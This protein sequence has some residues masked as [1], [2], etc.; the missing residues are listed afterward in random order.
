MPRF[1]KHTRTAAVG[2]RSYVRF[3]SGF[4]DHAGGDDA[5]LACG[6]RLAMRLT[7]P[8]ATY[9]DTGVAQDWFARDTKRPLASHERKE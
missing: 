2:S 5:L 8:R 4:R 1:F 9:L 6:S 3:G 7:L